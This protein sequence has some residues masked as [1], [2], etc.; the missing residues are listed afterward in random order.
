MRKIP[1][2]NIKKINSPIDSV[3]GYLVFCQW[4][5]LG[6]IWRYG[7]VGRGVSLKASYEVLKVH[8]IPVSS[9]S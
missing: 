3:L 2:K 1:N 9:F 6:R 5:C 7:L 8:A 4:K